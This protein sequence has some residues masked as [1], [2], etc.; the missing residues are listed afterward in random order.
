MQLLSAAENERFARNLPMRPAD[1][2]TIDKLQSQ[3]R[4]SATGDQPETPAI[5]DVVASVLR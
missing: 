1:R 5:A 4:S 3:L 2:P